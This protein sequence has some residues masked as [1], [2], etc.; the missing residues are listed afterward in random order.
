VCLLA[1]LFRSHPELP[2]VIG[3]NRDER[4]DRPATAMAVLRGRNPRVLG[5][6]DEEA[7]GT[8]F[9]LNDRGVFAGLTNRPPA[10]EPDRSKRSRG[11]LPLALA[12][13]VS[14]TVAVDEFRARFRP[15]DY[16]PAWILTGDRQAL[17][18]IDMT[19]T[20]PASVNQLEPGLHILENQPPG[21]E[22]PKVAHV[23]QLLAGVEALPHDALVA[24]LQEV[25]ADHDTPD[26]PVS[27]ACVHTDG[28]G[29]RWSGVVTVGA[30]E[31]GRPRFRYADGPPCR[32]PFIEA[33][34]W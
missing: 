13:H 3:A 10:T 34:L 28:Y 7:K 25:L 15:Q 14:A 33:R 30:D 18:A 8:W 6:R 32:V 23:R 24:R 27:A 5:G 9:A 31:T 20:G 21:T 26:G 1:V 2:L 11:E 19:G 22:S 16:N 17:F 4:L 29:T 12:T